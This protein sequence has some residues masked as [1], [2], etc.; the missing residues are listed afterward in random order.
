MLQLHCEAFMTSV[1]KKIINNNLVKGAPK[2]LSNGPDYEVIMGSIAYGVENDVSDMD[3]YGFIVPPKEFVFPHLRGEIPGFDDAKPLFD[4]YQEHHIK[5]PSAR[6]G[7]GRTYDFSIYSIVKFFKL[8]Q[9]N[10]PNIIDSLYVNDTHVL[11]ASEI[12]KMV[13]GNREVFLHKGCWAKFK[14]YAYA[15]VHKLKTKR[16]EGKRKKII[17]EFGYDIKFAYHVVRLLNEVEQLLLE[18]TMDLTKNCEQL[19]SIRRGEWSVERIDQF[20]LEKE[21]QLEESFHKSELPSK[22]RNKE[23][24]ALL[25]KCLEYKY[26]TIDQIVYQASAAEDAIQQ[27]K[28]II[29]K[30]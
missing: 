19:K 7:K 1:V 26:G 24:K 4:Q 21:K 2:F 18:G 13:R 11:H 6:G 28:L 29:D 17:E 3:V 10:N 9:E 5:D 12:G 8:L 15:Q 27:I 25:F 30:V 16:P 20:F 23:I 22:P 14:G